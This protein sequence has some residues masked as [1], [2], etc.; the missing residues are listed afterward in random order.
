MKAE[1]PVGAITDDLRHALSDHKQALIALLKE[2]AGPALVPRPSKGQISLSHFQERIWILQQLSPQAT[3]YNIVTAWPLGSKHPAAQYP[4]AIREVCSQHSILRT[5]YFE[6]DTGLAGREVGVEKVEIAEFDLSNLGV[7]EQH[8]SILKEIEGHTG[9]PFRLAD[10]PPVRFGVF[11]LGQNGVAVLVSAHHIALDHWSLSLLQSNIGRALAVPKYSQTSPNLDYADYAAW[12]RA[13]LDSQRLEAHIDWWVDRLSG[14]PGLCSFPADFVPDLVGRGNSI[15]FAWDH[16]LTADIQALVRQEGTSVYMCL[17]AA[18]AVALYG[19]TGQ[20]DLL[21]GNS[22]AVRDQPELEQIIG[23]FV[24]TEVLRLNVKGDMSFSDVLASAKAAVLD[25]HPHCQ[26]PFEMVVERL[27]PARS[28]NRSPLFQIAVVMQNAGD[29]QSEPIYGGGAVHDMTWFTHMRDNQLVGSIEYRS[30]IFA[31][32]SLERI[33]NSLEEI[34]RHASK[35]PRLSVAEIPL[36][37]TKEAELLAGFSQGSEVTTHV[38]LFVE[39]FEDV[40]QS[41]PDRIAVR[42]EDRSITYGVLNAK[43]NQLALHLASKGI[44]TGDLVGLCLDRSIDLSVVQLGILKSGAAFIPIDPQFPAE[45]VRYLLSD[46]RAAAIL[47]D[48]G[49]A[50]GF[51]FDTGSTTLIVCE[52]DP[53]WTGQETNNP[54]VR[55]AAADRAQVIYTSGSTGAPKG[56]QITHGAMANLFAVMR[57]EPG[58]GKEDIV[59]ASTT[60][61]FDISAVELLLPLSVGARIELLSRDVATDGFALAKALADTG[62]TVVQATPSAWRLLLEADWSGGDHVRAI[63]GGEPLTRD[64]ADRLLKKVGTLWNGYGPSE[65]TIYSTATYVQPGSDPISIGRP[66][67]NTQVVVLNESL[68]LTPIGVQGEICIGGAGVAI[69]YLDRAELTAEKFIDNPLDKGRLY[70]TGDIGCWMVNGNLMHLG[71]RDHQIKIR[72]VRV[73]LG[74]I[75]AALLQVPGIKEAAAAVHDADHDDRRLVAYVIYGWDHEVTASEVR[76]N[77]RE[78]LPGYMVPSLIVDLPEFPMTPNGKLDR[79]ALPSPFAHQMEEQVFEAPRAGMEEKLARIWQ[80]VLELDQVGA[81]DNF[82]EIGGH[83]LLTLRV[84]KQLRTQFGIE[85][86]PRVMFFQNLRQIAAKFSQ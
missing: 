82:F 75:E 85:L 2:E 9:R 16:D 7:E 51:G 30:D 79:E 14:S 42:F 45:R 58:L 70:R 52:D 35:N 25:S 20:S 33:L 63:T 80:D 71:R 29:G 32:S 84:A 47:A 10:E 38:P 73:E 37:S 24:N 64:L 67:D 59:A 34:L 15:S 31:R 78:R 8:D 11:D 21:L 18:C 69:G 5:L 44:G 81:T 13:A 60:V 49:T 40:A 72:G 74:E 27:Q 36:V 66:L 57:R 4:G 76:H 56:V 17:L 28:M 53:P 19:Y 1:A 12:S 83:S 86:D 43:A 23:P 41:E 77:L 62:A 22:I 46:C 50:D 61:S 39:S 48:R 65:T 55:A 54:T 26:V 6:A 3:E 68:K